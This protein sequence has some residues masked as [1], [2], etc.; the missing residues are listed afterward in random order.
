[1]RLR[2]LSD[3]EAFRAKRSQAWSAATEYWLR[4]SLRQVIDVGSS[5]VDA[6][7][8]SNNNRLSQQVIV[9][10]G[11]GEAWLLRALRH[12]G[13]SATYIGLDNHRDFL[14][15]LRRRHQSDANAS[16]VQVD[17]EVALPPELHGKA[18]IVVN[19]FNFFELADLPT[20]MKNCAALLK[21]GGIVHV[22]TI[23]ELSLLLAGSSTMADYRR[24]LS[25]YETIS[26]VKYWFQPIDLGDGASPTLSYASVMYSLPDYLAAAQ[27]AGLQMEGYVEV[28]KTSKTIPKIYRLMVFRG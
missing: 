1:M 22:S 21:P 6:V 20:A 19:A 10:A 24:N 28:V 2:A 9:D 5:I 4:G 17:L 14:A 25:D 7:M 13:S 11:C 16:F 12:R 27:S 18:D 26:G 3:I 15:E 8:S 23:D